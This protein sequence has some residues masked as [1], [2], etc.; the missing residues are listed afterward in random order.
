M[1]AKTDSRRS[2][3]SWNVSNGGPARQLGR[4]QARRGA[5]RR[6]SPT[7]D[8]GAERARFDAHPAAYNTTANGH[9]NR[10]WE[11]NLRRASGMAACSF[12]RDAA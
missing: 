12:L 3:W 10:M 8:L 1:L 9:A 7:S 4:T 11:H 5:Q 6:R 2:S